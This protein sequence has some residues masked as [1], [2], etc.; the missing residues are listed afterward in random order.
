MTEAVK[1]GAAAGVQRVAVVGGGTMGNGIAQVFATAG[2]DVAMV[3]VKPEF[4]ERALATIG[5]NLDRVAKKQE[6]PADRAPAILA[7][8]RG[9]TDVAAARDCQVAIEAVSED[10]AL[11]KKIFEALDELAPASTVLATNTSSISITEIAAVTK[12]ARPRDRHALHEPGAGHAAG[13]DHPRSRD[14]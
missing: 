7:R 9:G 2:I 14:Q 12:R 4:V 13:R 3:D 11:K 10:F 1:P 5:K 6:W 8:I